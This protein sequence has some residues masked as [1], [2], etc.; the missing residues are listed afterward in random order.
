M[1]NIHSLLGIK[2]GMTQIFNNKGNCLPATLVKLGPAEV[3]RKKTIQKDG[4]EALQIGFEE[5]SASKKQ[6]LPKAQQKQMP[7]RAY[8]FVK[9]VKTNDFSKYQVGDFFDVSSF[10]VGQFVDVIGISKGRG[11]AG[12]MKRHNF[13]GGPKSHGSHFH[14]A[15]GSIGASAYPARV[16]KNRKM[17]GHYGSARITSKRLEILGVEKEKSLLVIKGSIPGANGRLVEVRKSAKH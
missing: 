15:P 2:I 4:Y 14:R 17:P 16:F 6:N 12:V 13:A 7:K 11:F 5:L 9:E 8:Q 10:Q 3:L 1:E